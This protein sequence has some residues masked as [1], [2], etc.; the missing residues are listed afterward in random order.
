LTVYTIV[1]IY[2]QQGSHPGEVY[3]ASCVRVHCTGNFIV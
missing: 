3:N 2:D 1:T